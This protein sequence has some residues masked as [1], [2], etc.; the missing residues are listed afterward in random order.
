MVSN[1]SA[2]NLRRISMYFQRICP[3]E[4]PFDFLR[5]KLAGKPYVALITCDYVLS[6]GWRSKSLPDATL[7]TKKQIF[8][9][10]LISF[11][12]FCR[13]INYEDREARIDQHG[14]PQ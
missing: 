8:V 6:S 3:S 12:L 11:L 10:V 7:V 9:Y 4:I 14:T 2:I 13:S 1:P 5:S